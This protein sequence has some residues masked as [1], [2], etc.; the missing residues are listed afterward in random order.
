MSTVQSSES[1]AKEETITLERGEE[2]VKNLSVIDGEILEVADGEKSFSKTEN[3]RSKAEIITTEQKRTKHEERIRQTAV[4]AYI[5]LPLIFLTVA[6]LGGLRIEAEN[7]AFLFLK[8][9]LIC[10]IFAS[11]LLVLFFRAGLIRLDG[12]FSENFSTLKNIANAL[13]LLALFAASTQ[14]FNSLLPERGLPFWII[15]FCFFWTLWNNLFS[16]FNPKKLIKSLGGTFA[17]AFAVKY[18]VLANLSAPPSDSLWQRMTE[19]PTREAFTWLLDLPRFAAATGYIQFFTLVF[20]L[21]GLFLL[22]PEMR[23]GEA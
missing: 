8:P 23:D 4:R 11:V 20:Y 10:L 3:L 19:S 18:L 7:S 15:A 14:I 21:I 1:K 17:L 6:L 9:A 5:L 16:E 22:K 13:V 12:W 2:E